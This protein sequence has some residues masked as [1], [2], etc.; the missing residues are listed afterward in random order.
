MD[1]LVVLAAWAA[2]VVTGVAAVY[3]G[4]QAAIA[5]DAL[6][7]TKRLAEDQRQPYV[8]ADIRADEL[9]PQLVVV[10]VDNAGPTVASKICVLFDPPLRNTARDAPPLARWEISALT[11]GSRHARAMGAGPTFLPA[12]GQSCRVTVDAVGPGGRAIETLTY[13]LEIHGLADNHAAKPW[14][15]RVAES[16]EKI[17]D[18]LGGNGR[19]GWQPPRTLPPDWP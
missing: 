10:T 14:T 8:F 17:S 5:H 13:D 9:Q 1:A 15:L 7:H 19:T 18:S 6:E 3:S 12:N 16:M 2:A 11:P 4:W